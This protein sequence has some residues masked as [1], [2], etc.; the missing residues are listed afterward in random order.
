MSNAVN[1]MIK[2]NNNIDTID[3][4]DAIDTQP[5]K[6]VFRFKYEKNIQD[7]VNEFSKLNT[8]KNREDFNKNWEIFIR[9]NSEV[10]DRERERVTRIGYSGNF[11]EKLYKSARYY[12]SKKNSLNS[13]SLNSN[14]LNSNSLCILTDK[15]EKPK[16]CNN[17]IFVSDNLLSA[18]DKHIKD[19]YLN[20]KYKPSTGY[21]E[22][23]NKN[24]LLI[25][26]EVVILINDYGLEKSY[27]F[28]KLKKTYKNRYYQITKNL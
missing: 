5:N 2:E 28:F 22:F 13:N 27:I 16:L 20:E 18:I 4:I 26:S 1:N 8:N 3:A 21:E 11:D 24:K 14:S 9:T 25:S 23:S 6:K 7:L 12:Y 17:Y 15:I 10:L 19:N